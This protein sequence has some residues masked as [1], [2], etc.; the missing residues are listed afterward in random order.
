MSVKQL[1][2]YVLAVLMLMTAISSAYA[3]EPLPSS[4]VAAPQDFP[5][6][7]HM[8]LLAVSDTA[9]G[10]K[11]ITADLYLEVQPGE[12]RVFIESFPLTKM[13]TQ[14]STRFAKEIACSEI[15]LDC[16][17][18]NFFYTIKADTALVGGPSAGAAAAV[19]TASVLQGWKV[20]ESIAM[21]GTINSGGLVGPVGGLKEKISAAPER[22]IRKILIPEG[23]RYLKPARLGNLTNASSTGKNNDTIDLVEFGKSQGVDVIEVSDLRAAL[24]EFTG[25]GFEE[26]SGSLA[27]DASYS[28][29]MEY[30]ANLL[31]NK[32]ISMDSSL[33]GRENFSGEVKEVYD[34]A[35][36]LSRRGIDS[37][38]SRQFYSSASYC[39][40][41]NVRYRY[42]DF[43]SRNFSE[44][45]FA[46]AAAEIRKEAAGLEKSIPAYVTITDLQS[47][48][49][50]K[51]RLL[52]AED[53]INLSLQRL[54]QNRTSEALFALAYAKERVF[55]AY[56]W[57]QF[58][59]KEGNKF[60]LDKEALEASCR[61]K[62]SEAEER[63]EYAKLFMDGSLSNTRRDIDRA[64]DDLS[65][66]NYELCLSKAAKAKAESDVL[67]STL[68]VEEESVATLVARKLLA[69]ERTIARQAS[70][71]VFPIV[72]YSYYEYATSL[73]SS[74]PYSALL[75][76]EYAIELSNLD[77]YFRK[78]VKQQKEEKRP[79]PFYND[80]SF[81]FGAAVGAAAVIIIVS[82][83]FA[84][85]R[86]SS[87]KPVMKR[88]RRIVK[89]AAV[90]RR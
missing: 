56:S 9:E 82:A 24:A 27:I 58:F 36:N 29:T 28:A 72:G 42:L 37:L 68:G 32:S 10:Y 84:I 39:F 59:G 25:K 55:S 74:D 85:R 20:D 83:V 70:R 11:G 5:K 34:S 65:D 12:G 61:S 86:F 79:L 73:N 4:S 19:L 64:Y 6:K 50:V 52:D 13:D 30:L 35:V 49:A 23:E 2:V 60:V 3:S 38:K 48:A 57:S 90:R 63:Y 51:E 21:T 89:K 67:L 7:G 33:S 47:Y 43:D 16:D 15:N 54:S 53:N 41:A 45:D 31:C 76:S 62:I 40:G 14:I 22:G 26:S 88:K 78:S 1:F 69:A 77:I 46:D 87:K 71:G 75:Y 81:A 18:L 17:R 66:G 80:A 8:K 44:K